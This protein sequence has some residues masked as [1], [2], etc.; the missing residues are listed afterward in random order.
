MFGQG[1]ASSGGRVISASLLLDDQ[2]TIVHL[3]DALQVFKHVLRWL[4]NWLVLLQ[5][6]DLWLASL[7]SL[8]SHASATR[9]GSCFE[10]ATRLVTRT[11]RV[12]RGTWQA[13]HRSIGRYVGSVT[14]AHEGFKHSLLT[15]HKL[16]VSD[17]GVTQPLLVLLGST[18]DLQ[19]AHR[20][21]FRKIGDGHLGLLLW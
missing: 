2:G 21:N 19:S 10:G 12:K 11:V 9:N 8:T 16:V 5:S 18:L 4:D 7:T 15:L 20:C 1:L 6:A 3:L 14:S 17:R 13:S